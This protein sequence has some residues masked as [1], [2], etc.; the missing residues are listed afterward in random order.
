VR[1]DVSILDRDP[2]LAEDL[3]DEQFAIARKQVVAD[4]ESYPRGVWAVGS[5]DFDHVASLGLL[6]LEGL[7]ARQVTVGGHT[8]AEILGPG[9]VLQ[10]WL[11]VGPEPSV[12]TRST[13]RWSNRRRQLCSIVRSAPA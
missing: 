7:L 1:S 13:G 2:D 8:C 4:V 11:L 6:L 3:S 9:D 10:P 12:A 5:G